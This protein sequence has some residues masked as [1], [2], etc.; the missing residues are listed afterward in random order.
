MNPRG[1]RRGRGGALAALLLIATMGMSGCARISPDGGMLV[2]E[3]TASNELGK[4]V[5]KIRDEADAA[6]VSA[7]VKALLAKPL[8]VSNAVQIALIN[9]R[10]LQAA[11]NELGISEAEMVEAS[12]PP[13]RRCRFCGLSAPGVSRSNGRSCRTCWGC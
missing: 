12:L 11:F 3:A 2:V 1:T 4:D 5:V 13:H 6:A 7:R 8:S 10:G 9:N